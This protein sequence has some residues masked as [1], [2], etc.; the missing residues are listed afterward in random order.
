MVVATMDSNFY[1]IL[2][3]TIERRDQLKLEI[4]RIIAFFRRRKVTY[5]LYRSSN[6]IL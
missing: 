4:S 2:K 6:I 5:N 1:T 3:Q